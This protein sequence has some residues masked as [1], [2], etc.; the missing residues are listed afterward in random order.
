MTGFLF[1]DVSMLRLLCERIG[2]GEIWVV[3]GVLMSRNPSSMLLFFNP[4]TGWI[5][6]SVFLSILR[7][8]M[9]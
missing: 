9:A 5:G 4:A 7:D 3:L 6:A 2:Y 8:A 1:T